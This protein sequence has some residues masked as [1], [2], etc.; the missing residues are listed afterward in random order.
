MNTISRTTILQ[1]L[2]YQPATGEFRWRKSRGKAKRLSVAGFLKPDGYKFIKISG[3]DY[4]AHRLAYFLMNNEWPET[5]DHINNHPSDNRAI[6]IRA[7]T[8]SQN[9]CNRRLQRN[10]TSGAKGVRWNK[11]RRKW[12]GYVW[13]NKKMKH[14][15]YF[16]TREEACSAVYTVRLEMH[17]EFANHGGKA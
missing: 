5:V 3:K 4:P 14:I 16:S 1:L 12:L 6:N 7:A 11:Q 8:Q 2:I 15:G 13:L 17:G 9:N 10:N